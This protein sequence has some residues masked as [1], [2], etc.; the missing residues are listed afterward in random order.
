MCRQTGHLRRDCH[1]TVVE[2]VSEGTMLDR[3]T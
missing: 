3:S 2:E 1:G